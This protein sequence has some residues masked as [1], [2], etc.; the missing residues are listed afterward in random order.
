MTWAGVW[1]DPGTGLFEATVGRTN[2]SF[3]ETYEILAGR[4]AGLAKPV[5]LSLRNRRPSHKGR[6][7]ATTRTHPLKVEF[8]N[9]YPRETSD[10]GR[11]DGAASPSW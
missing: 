3:R 7:A 2:R 6:H 8:P 9:D 1:A 10:F 4:F 5:S 11:P